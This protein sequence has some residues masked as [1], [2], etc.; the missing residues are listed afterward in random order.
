MLN[1]ETNLCTKKNVLNHIFLPWEKY[2]WSYIYNKEYF[3]VTYKITSIVVLTLAWIWTFW[4][5]TGPTLR[6]R[7][8]N[9]AGNQ[10]AITSFNY[11]NP[12]QPVIC[13]GIFLWTENSWNSI[14]VKA[15]ISNCMHV[16]QWD[17]VTHPCPNF[18]LQLKLVE[19]R[20]CGSQNIPQEI[21]DVIRYPCSNLS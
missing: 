13:R 11:A 8:P 2:S 9:A 20:A 16:K 19:F 4:S 1:I 10:T 21:V 6:Q 15:W 7:L 12:A 5:N 3:I 17:V 18:K 14:W